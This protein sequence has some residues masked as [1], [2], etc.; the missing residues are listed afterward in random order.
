MVSLIPGNQI[1]QLA[2]ILHFLKSKSTKSEA[3]D[4]LLTKSNTFLLPL[5]LQPRPGTLKEVGRA[6][7]MLFLLPGMFI[8]SDILG[9]SSSSTHFPDEN[10]LG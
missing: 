2:F 5:L 10:E 4:E 3:H 1:H 8:A 9:P 7:A 6:S